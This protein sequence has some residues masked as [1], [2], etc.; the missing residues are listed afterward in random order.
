[1]GR[2]NGISGHNPGLAYPTAYLRFIP[3]TAAFETNNQFIK[4]SRGIGAVGKAPDVK[5]LPRFP[6]LG[7]SICA[8]LK[9]GLFPVNEPAMNLTPKRIYH[10]DLEVVVVAQAFVAEVLRKFFAMRNCIGICVELGPDSISVRDTVFHIEE[11]HLHR[12]SSSS[13]SRQRAAAI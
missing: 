10:G 2:I 3:S 6:V 11:I 5:G 8:D 12:V 9:H 7:D 13:V 4:I 1:M